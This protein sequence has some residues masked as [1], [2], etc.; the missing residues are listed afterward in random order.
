MLQ[1]PGYIQFETNTSCKGAC[2]FCPHD[3]VKRA[4]LSDDTI[5][6]IIEQCMP[7]A[8]TVCP[9]LYQEPAQEPRLLDILHQIKRVKNVNNVLFSNM[10]SWND[11]Q[12]RAL[13]DSQEVDSMN[14]SFYGPTEALYNKY[15]PGFDWRKTR[16]NIRY[17]Y[18][19]MVQRGSRIPYIT[20]QYLITP[21]LIDAYPAFQRDW[22]MFAVKFVPFDPFHGKI[23]NLST[24]TFT[25]Q[26]YKKN[27]KRVACTRPWNTLNIL[28]TGDV[29]PC[30]LDFKPEMVMGNVKKTTI[31]DIWNGKPFNDFRALHTDGRFNDIPLCKKCEVWKW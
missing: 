31:S 29:V 14:V 18:Y 30:C 27:A 11:E 1:L 21:D 13:V 16:H 7:T 24:D 28:S 5:T 9:F 12:L 22:E 2:V 26:Y 15:Q 10:A 19:Y 4:P 17:L 8:D 20:M 25:S 3:K 6:S 23:Q